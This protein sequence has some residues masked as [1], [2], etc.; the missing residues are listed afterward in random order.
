MDMKLTE[1]KMIPESSEHHTEFH[2]RCSWSVPILMD[3]FCVTRI[4]EKILFLHGC[5]TGFLFLPLF[6]PTPSFLSLSPSPFFF[7]LSLSLYF[8]SFSLSCFS[9]SLSPPPSHSFFLCLVAHSSS[10]F[11]IL[12][13]FRL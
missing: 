13:S 1:R 11:F 2:R 8:F 7:I 9:L 10:R 3:L 5:P 4:T 6:P 12:F